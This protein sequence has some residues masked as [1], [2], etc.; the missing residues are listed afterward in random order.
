MVRLRLT[1]FRLAVVF[2][3]TFFL[4]MAALFALIY[5]QSTIF[6]TG[7]FDSI[8]TQRAAVIV[9]MP[10]DQWASAVEERVHEDPGHLLSAGLFS[11]E[12]R[13]LAG[14]VVALPFRATGRARNATIVR[15]DPEGQRTQRIRAIVRRLSG[16]E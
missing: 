6:L 15:I 9:A 12:G 4:C 5:W 1:S 16:G 10:P 11:A 7:R 8:I 3:G 13:R 14:N 2:A